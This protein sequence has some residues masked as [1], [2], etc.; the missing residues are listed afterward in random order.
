ML[1]GA[2]EVYFARMPADFRKSFTG[3]TALAIGTL[4]KDPHAGGLFVF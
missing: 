2:G 3:L 1:L 4:K